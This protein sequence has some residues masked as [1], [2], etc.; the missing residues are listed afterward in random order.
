M[1]ALVYIVLAW[2]TGDRIAGLLAGDSG[3]A[4]PPGKSWWLRLSSGFG[5]GILTV[6]WMVYFTAWL[7]SAY[8]D[9]DE[10]LMKANMSVLGF[11]GLLLIVSAIIRRVRGRAFSSW[12]TLLP[13]RKSEAA[14]ALIFLAFLTAIFFYVF[15][16]RDGKLYSGLTVFSDYAPHTAMI[17]S[18]SHE[19]NYPTGYPHFGGQDIR[20]HFM[21][22]FLTGNL[23]YLGMRL[24]IAYNVMSVL[25]LEAFW[26]MLLAFVNRLGCGTGVW[27]LTVLLFLFRS[28]TTFFRYL[29][30]HYQTGDLIRAL[31]DNTVFIGYT[32]NENWGLW[33][34]NVYLNQRHLAFGL[35]IAALTIWIF[36]D[37]VEAG[38]EGGKKGFSWAGGLWF[39]A[40]AWKARSPEKALLAGVLL[41]LTT[42][43]NGAAVIGA[44]LILM[45]FAVFSPGKLDYLLLAAVTVLFS[46]LQSRLFIW[47]Q[48]VSF[49]LRPGFLAQPATPAG[50]L[51]YLFQITGFFIIGC[52]FLFPVLRRTERVMLT[53]CLFPV[54]FAFLV[55]LTAD[56]NVNHKY[57]VIG[58]AF[59]TVFWANALGRLFAGGTARACTA[60]II[61]VCLTAT[62]F[63]DFVIILRNNGEGHRV[64]VNMDSDVTRWLNE[65]LDSTDLILTPQYS[66]NEVTI[67]GVMMYCGWPYY[68]WSAGYD[69]YYRGDRQ[70][71]MYT[72]AS[73]D[74]LRTLAWQ[75]GITYILFE[76]DMMI[77]DLP[78][79]EDAIQAAFPLVYDF[80]RLRIYEV[81]DSAGPVRPLQTAG[82]GVGN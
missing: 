9:M 31:R 43:W 11:T 77:G 42:F 70:A 4:A 50:V 53:A 52:F 22:Q 65:H 1:L 7:L 19:N 30:E 6:T 36:M 34:F 56:I 14:A 79:R 69:T 26:L 68:P 78:A 38:D 37:W 3:S 18:F 63:Y 27:V 8:T 80:E 29:W 32:E 81:T 74:E 54:A 60:L 24:D 48:A 45:G 21:F 20:Y 16:I 12:G 46:V 67:S 2:L 72:T 49:S 62:G 33:C 75:E 57:I 10:P 59:M 71:L 55:S 40:R 61:T 44:L 13:V 5:V 73:P 23:E 51:V 41:W 15:Y 64:T 39:S 17:R 28:G 47:G 58:Y 35:L 25:S 82:E 66:M 76:D